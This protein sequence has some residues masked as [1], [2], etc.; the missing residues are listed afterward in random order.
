MNELGH[1]LGNLYQNES[2]YLNKVLIV[3]EN[4]NLKGKKIKVDKPV[5]IEI[6]KPMRKKKIQT[7]C[8]YIKSKKKKYTERI[9]IC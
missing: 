6:R 2:M 4:V 5:L 9:F 7:K 8:I 3:F 1:W